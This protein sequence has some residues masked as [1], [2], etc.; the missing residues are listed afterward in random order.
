M[1]IS[2]VL[3]DNR[4]TLTVCLIMIL[5]RIGI[6]D[7][8]IRPSG[9]M[10]RAFDGTKTSTYGEIDLK[11]TIGPCE[12]EISFVVVDVPALFNRLLGRPRIHTEWGHPV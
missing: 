1:I 4:S 11:A 10:V 3:I 7:S 5:G 9:L 8:L 12:F 2:R 6:D